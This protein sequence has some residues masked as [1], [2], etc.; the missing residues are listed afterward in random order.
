MCRAMIR[1]LAHAHRPGRFDEWLRLERNH[2]AAD[3]AGHRQPVDRADDEVEDRDPVD[4]V[5]GEPAL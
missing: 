3:D 5:V 2:L 4:A 1:D